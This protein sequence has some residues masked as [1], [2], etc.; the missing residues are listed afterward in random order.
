M[1]VLQEYHAPGLSADT[2]AQWTRVAS[3]FERAGARVHEVSL[4]HTQY[5]IVCYHVLCCCEVASN[6]ARFDGLQYGEIKDRQ[7]ARER[8]SRCV[9]GVF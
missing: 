5:S 6:M 8:D 2:L 9:K 4:P 3:L 7:S 1:C